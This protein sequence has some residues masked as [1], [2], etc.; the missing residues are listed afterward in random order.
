MIPDAHY[1][2][3]EDLLER[4]IE[5]AYSEGCRE[6]YT[7]GALGFDTMAAK[8]LIAYRMKH[9]D[10]R[11]IVVVP[12][13]NQAEKWSFGDKEIYEYILSS[14]DEVVFCSTEYTKDCMKLRNEYLADTCDILIAYCGRYTSG[15]AQTIRMAKKKGKTVYNL[16]GSASEQNS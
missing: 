8:Q 2:K 14:A 13:E 15:A 16:F 12:C 4:A 7:G 3:L 5:F 1:A 11:L 10:L 6:F 9:T